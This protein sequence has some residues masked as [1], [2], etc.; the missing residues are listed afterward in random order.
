MISK[1]LK[2]TG[3][4]A[5]ELLNKLH[6]HQGGATVVA[7]YGDL[8]SG[9]TTFT[10]AFAKALGIPEDDITSPT[11][12]IEKIFDIGNHHHFKKFIHIDAYRLEKPEEIERLGWKET[13]SDKGNLIFVEW[14]ENKGKALPK[15]AI[16]LSFKFIDENKR[17]IVFN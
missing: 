17:E 1:N 9:K 7:L 14:A 3:N 11:F 10:K 13:V 4:I 16:K 12:V 6:P 2:D 5:Q 15:D 8:G